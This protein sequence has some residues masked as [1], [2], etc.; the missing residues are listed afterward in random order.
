LRRCA[1]VNNLHIFERHPE[2]Q[3]ALAA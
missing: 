1:V 3:A 2:I